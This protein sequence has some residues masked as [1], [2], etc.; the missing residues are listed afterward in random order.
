MTEPSPR[1]VRHALWWV[2]GLHL[3]L[4]ALAPLLVLTNGVLP[5]TLADKVFA[6]CAGA[7]MA[8]LQLRHVLSAVRGERPAY[9]Q[10]TLLAQVAIAFAPALHLG[11]DW[12]STQ[13]VVAAAAMIL[14][15][16]RA[17]PIV[18]FGVLAAGF[19]VYAH[20]LV[21]LSDPE[22]ATNLG[23]Y[24]VVGTIFASVLYGTVRLVRTADELYRTRIELAEVAVDRERVVVS[25]DLHD[26]L[27]QS[28][29]AISLKGDLAVRLLGRDPARAYDEITSLTELAR[30]ARR[31]IRAITFGDHQVSL[32]EE[33]AAA[34]RLLAAAG[35]ETRITLDPPD[36]DLPEAARQ[37]LAWAIREGT[38]NLLRHS[39]A[40]TC[41]IRLTRAATSVSLEM[42]NDGLRHS[43][44]AP[45]SGLTGLT[46]R[47]HDLGGTATAQS[48]PD[49]HFHLRFSLP[50][51]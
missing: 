18:G 47:A 46:D 45:G 50:L 27:G 23:Y 49:N 35:V 4:L 28:L 20:Q 34:E 51:R 30:S 11:P 41:E 38:T 44:S 37:A 36:P 16:G 7:L 33:I 31:D 32:P 10:W 43:A 2:V 21:E 6:V 14:L 48:T 42:T 17:V 24:A 5:H 25:R 9:W 22:V 8:G 26:L 1:L 12:G 15:R 39:D 29:S 19:V 13:I 3:A 40:T